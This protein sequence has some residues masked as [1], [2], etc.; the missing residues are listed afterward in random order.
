MI[1]FV[2]GDIFESNAEALVNPVNTV[3]VM[4][5]GLALEFKKRYPY[6][7]ALYVQACK[8]S[9]VCIGKMHITTITNLVV[10]R[11]FI[12]NFPTK[13]VY[14]RNSR[15]I[16]IIEGLNALREFLIENKVK[17]VAI[18]A[19][20]AGLGGLKWEEVKFWIL[21]TLNGLPDVD[22][23]VYLPREE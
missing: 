20:G 18:P 17:S 16:W 4:G 8:A 12:V 1:R 13:Q 21:N 10:G 2:E 7:F 3:G 15:L 14:W 23:M 9:E 22:I 6:N 5:K 19:L 11:R